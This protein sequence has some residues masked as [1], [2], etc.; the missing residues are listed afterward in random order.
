MSFKETPVQSVLFSRSGSVLGSNTIIKELPVVNLT[1]S[2]E[3]YL[4]SVGRLKTPN[5]QRVIENS[6]SDHIIW[7]EIDDDPII[8][9]NQTPYSLHEQLAASSNLLGVTLSPTRVEKIEERAKVDIELESQKYESHL[10][11]HNLTTSGLSPLWIEI[12]SKNSDQILTPKSLFDNIQASSTKRVEYF[13]IPLS[14]SASPPSA[15]FEEFVSLFTNITQR[16]DSSSQ[17]QFIIQSK[18]RNQRALIAELT[19]LLLHHHFISPCSNL[20]LPTE[21][22]DTNQPEDLKERYLR[23]EYPTILN[24]LRILE[25]GKVSKGQVDVLINKLSS[26]VNLLQV[27]WDIRQEAISALHQTSVPRFTALRTYSVPSIDTNVQTM[28][29][30]HALKLYFDL[31]V[32]A[33]YLNSFFRANQESNIT[34]PKPSYQAWLKSR[35]EFVL[36][37][38]DFSKE[39]VKPKDQPT[40]ESDRVVLQRNFKVLSWGTLLKSDHFPGCFS[41]PDSPE[42]TGAPNFRQVPGFPVFGVGQATMDGIRFVIRKI[43]QDSERSSIVW[44]NLREEPVLYINSRPFVLRNYDQPFS[45]VEYTGISAQRIEQTELQLKLEVLLEAKKHNGRVLL[46][47]ETLEGIVPQWEQVDEHSVLT[48]QEVYATLNLEFNNCI[49]FARIP[50]TDEKTPEKQDFDELVERVKRTCSTSV[51]YVF[52][53]QMGRGRT[54]TGLVVGCLLCTLLIWE[55]LS[56]PLKDDNPGDIFSEAVVLKL[57]HFRLITEVRKLLYSG[58]ASKR[59][60]DGVIDCCGALQNLRESIYPY[61]QTYRD[62]PSDSK[63][64]LARKGFVNYLERYF[65]LLLF[66]AYIDREAANRFSKSFSCWVDSHPEFESVKEAYLQKE[67]DMKWIPGMHEEIEKQVEHRGAILCTGS[68]LKADCAV[69]THFSDYE[70]YRKIKGF[71]VHGVGQPT[72]NGIRKILLQTGARFGAGVKSIVWVNLREEPVIYINERPYVVRTVYTQFENLQYPGISRKRVKELCTR[73]RNDVVFEA[74]RYDGRILLYRETSYQNMQSD[75][76]VVRCGSVCKLEEAY[77][78]LASDG[79]RVRYTCI[80]LYSISVPT[81]E[82]TRL[83]IDLVNNTPMNVDII[84]NCMKGTGR[85][86]IGLFIS[87]LTLHFS[88]KIPLPEEETFA[89][90]G[91]DFL[92]EKSVRSLIRILEHGLESSSLVVRVVNLCIQ[93]TQPTTRIDDTL[94]CYLLIVAEYLQSHHWPTSPAQLS[95]A[96]WWISRPELAI[97]YS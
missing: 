2:I 33:E 40:S 91:T 93:D 64:Q 43:L 22:L 76:E 23:G 18:A 32:F 31:I 73:L 26:P 84:F 57:G 65:Y 52:N 21:Q 44:T 58:L 38:E 4:C 92:E 16:A 77:E 53:C 94:F 88:R 36:L 96:N 61:L 62:P 28:Q 75:W 78:L 89:F 81:L 12:D 30:N 5:I 1:E 67:I 63:R 87:V 66:A 11:I 8:Y 49:D 14:T 68:F 80:P 95:F 86:I 13:R 41:L 25:F 69:P 85:T 46:H 42:S 82:A 90:N 83:L 15:T 37:G 71:P 19:V 60:L 51:T 79:F 55:K 6:S 50:I 48:L 9:I 47:N 56:I 72:I 10:L 59:L 27:I 3:K 45:N 34:S 24:L 29:F 17:L 39:L 70:N 7:I 20:Y 97:F 54:T 35:P 74:Q